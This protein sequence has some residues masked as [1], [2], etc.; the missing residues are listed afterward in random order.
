MPY[1][2]SIGSLVHDRLRAG[3]TKPELVRAGIIL[4]NELALTRGA[5][6]GRVAGA[7]S[8]THAGNTGNGVMGAITPGR[9][10]KEGRYKLLITAAA[11][12][13]GTFELRGP[14]GSL[15][16]SGTVAVAFVSDHMSF[17]LADGATDFIV[18]DAF[19]I[20]VAQGTKYRHVN[21]ANTDGSGTPIG[22]LLKDIATSVSDTSHDV[23]IAF[24]GEFNEAALTFGGSEALAQHRTALE[25]RG[26]YLRKSQDVNGL[27]S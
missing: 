17:T 7:I 1:P 11:S 25:E 23:A 22:V 26:L 14:D 24:E 9:L 18:G 20:N 5:V 13:A 4:A 10:V 6:L 27:A 2:T 21:S 19:I 15:I 12:N 16:S 3:C 8:E